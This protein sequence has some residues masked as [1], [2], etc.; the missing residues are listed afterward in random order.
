MNNR[1]GK[2][3]DDSNKK[4]FKGC[5]ICGKNIANTDDIS[6]CEDCR[7]NNRHANKKMW[8][9]YYA[10]LNANKLDKKTAELANK[11]TLGLN[12]KVSSLKQDSSFRSIERAARENQK[13]SDLSAV[14]AQVLT[15]VPGVLKE[16]GLSHKVDANLLVDAIVPSKI[17]KP[18]S[19]L[20]FAKNILKDIIRT[21]SLDLFPKNYLPFNNS[22]KTHGEAKKVDASSLLN[23]GVIRAGFESELVRNILAEKSEESDEAEKSEDK[24]VEDKKEDVTASKKEDNESSVEH[25]DDEEFQEILDEKMHPVA[26]IF[27]GSVRRH[28]NANETFQTRK[29]QRQ[30][31]VKKSD[32]PIFAYAHKNL[33]L[34]VEVVRPSEMDKQIISRYTPIN[35]FSALYKDGKKYSWNTYKTDAGYLMLSANNVSNNAAFHSKSLTD[36]RDFVASDSTFAKWTNLPVEASAT[37]I[38]NFEDD[39]DINDM[40]EQ[41]LPFLSDFMD[42]YDDDAAED[43]ALET[44]NHVKNTT[45]SDLGG[46]VLNHMGKHLGEHVDSAPLHPQLKS[47][48]KPYLGVAHKSE[49]GNAPFN[50]AAKALKP[51]SSE[52][53]EEKQKII[54]QI[55]EQLKLA[56]DEDSK[57]N[58]LAR[59]YEAT[60][61]LDDEG[62]KEWLPKIYHSLHDSLQDKT[63]EAGKERAE[64]EHKQD[65]RMKMSPV[66]EVMEITSGLT[67]EKFEDS[68][69]VLAEMGYSEEIILAAAEKMFLKTADD[70]GGECFSPDAYKGIQDAKP[71]NKPDLLNPDEVDA[72]T[73]KSAT[74]SDSGSEFT[75][76]EDRE[77]KHIAETEEKEGKSSEEAKSIGY[78]TVNKEK[79][80]D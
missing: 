2:N 46:A 37:I 5:S 74:A 16:L 45:A 56:E 18:L 66:M 33:K 61:H 48:I 40:A 24:E 73:P 53:P 9:K 63:N 42:N 51:I 75:E 17:D 26:N 70:E 80:E 10:D 47:A 35:N 32:M 52:I 64:D 25:L 23:E 57:V 59:F 67:P 39:D 21:A 29:L 1:I 71:E 6:F 20:V 77:A 43:I 11:N 15:Y 65:L 22:F 19:D 8:Q 78:A 27:S 60:P 31:E 54:A 72:I 49:H 55:V 12:A 28:S 4:T 13:E 36:F 69:E 68:L 38:L 50:D 79:N 58:L 76:K 44:A 30:E 3:N 7:K 34:P 62:K 41:I 14:K